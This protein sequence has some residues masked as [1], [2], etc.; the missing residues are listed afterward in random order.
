MFANFVLIIIENSF[1]AF[2]YEVCVFIMASRLD[3]IVKRFMKRTNRKMCDLHPTYIMKFVISELPKRYTVVNWRMYL[4]KVKLNVSGRFDVPRNGWPNY[5][6]Y[7]RFI[8]SYQKWINTASSYICRYFKFIRTL[9]TSYLLCTDN[10]DPKRKVQEVVF[11][12]DPIEGDAG[13]LNYAEHPPKWD[14]PEGTHISILVG[15]N[16][17]PLTGQ[18]QT[19]QFGEETNCLGRRRPKIAEVGRTGEDPL[20]AAHHHSHG[21]APSCGGSVVVVCASVSAISSLWSSP[22]ASDPRPTPYLATGRL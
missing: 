10:G 17:M 20:S 16:G 15:G 2:E 12:R 22:P 4:R 14:G 7:S 18:D 9:A 11:I 5:Y 3:R 8:R 1:K 19:K 6:L 13:N 21:P